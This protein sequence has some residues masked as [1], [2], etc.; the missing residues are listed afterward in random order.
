[1]FCIFTLFKPFQ[2]KH[3]THLMKNTIKKH[4][5]H[6]KALSCCLET[7]SFTSVHSPARGRRAHQLGQAETPQ[8]RGKPGQ[9]RLAGAWQ[10][11]F[12]L[13]RSA[14]NLFNFSPPASSGKP[15]PSS[16]PALL[17]RFQPWRISI[18]VAPLSTL[19]SCTAWVGSSRQQWSRTVPVLRHC[20]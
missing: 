16:P 13:I 19:P 7:P 20:P 10:N 15:G 3:I 5:V 2:L 11:E 6:E 12:L 4:I 14:G 8:S 17:L 18:H 9:P 1:M